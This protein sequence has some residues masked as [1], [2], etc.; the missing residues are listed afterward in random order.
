[1]QL[2]KPLLRKLFWG[3]F[4]HFLSDKQ[5]AKVRYWL[6]LEAHLNLEDP[7]KFTEKIQ[8][9]KLFE[10]TPL[11]KKVADRTEVRK[12]IAQKAGEDY[13]I[14]LI[15]TYDELNRKTW[16]SLPSQFVLKANH[17]CGMIKIIRDKKNTAFEEVRQKTQQW[18]QTDYAELGREWVY[19]DLP[20]TILAEKLLLDS[21]HTIPSDYK[22]FCFN[23]RVRLIQIDF[24]RFGEQK[25]N[26]Y[27]S[28]FNRL[29]AKL[30]YPHNPANIQKP[31]N[32]EEAVQLAETLSS[33]FNFIRVDLYLLEDDIYFGELTNYPGNGF[34]AFEPESMEY[35]VGSWLQLK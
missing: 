30:L 34:A 35:K 7:K 20:R 26:L 16:E 33:E 23:G 27:D 14:P 2:I 10:R 15:G 5:Y 28:N 8:Y 21:E 6:E 4:R 1:M 12:Y 9:I 31:P 32:L 22:F 13:L 18:K 25:R 3:L 29:E 24:D 19:R 17:G 11:R